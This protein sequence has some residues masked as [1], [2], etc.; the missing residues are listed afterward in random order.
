MYADESTL[1][2]ASSTS[3]EQ[4]RHS[5]RVELHIINKCVKHIQNIT[6]TLF[7]CRNALVNT[8]ALNL[9]IYGILVSRSPRWKGHCY[10]TD[11]F[12]FSWNTLSNN[13]KQVKNR[14][15]SS[16]SH[17]NI[18]AVIYHRCY[19]YYICFGT[20]LLFEFNCGL[21][22]LLLGVLSYFI[23]FLIFMPASHS[24]FGLIDSVQF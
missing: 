14:F 3:V 12:M 4:Q 15:S 9:F 20:C 13:F 2:C 6:K 11:M 18:N 10:F 19:W 17:L 21:L 5:N 16:R 24:I 8:T 22:L 23:W 1:F 7:G